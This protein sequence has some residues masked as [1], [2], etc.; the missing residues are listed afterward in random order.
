MVNDFTGITEAPEPGNVTANEEIVFI[1]RGIASIFTWK[2]NNHSVDFEEHTM[3]ING[4]R[5]LLTITV[6]FHA[7][8][9]LMIL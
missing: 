7:L 4:L 8:L 1:C 2:I 9:S 3:P 6:V 5:L